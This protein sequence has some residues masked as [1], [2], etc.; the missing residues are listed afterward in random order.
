VASEGS[1]AASR[2]QR[3]KH[4]MNDKKPA[5][6]PMDKKPQVTAKPATEMKKSPASNKTTKR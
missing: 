6:K 5:A 1:M 2:H 3:R 4:A